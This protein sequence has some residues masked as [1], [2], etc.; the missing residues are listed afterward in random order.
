V[1]RRIPLAFL[2]AAQEMLQA[3]NSAPE[4]RANSDAANRMLEEIYRYYFPRTPRSGQ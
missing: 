2:D 1:A 4:V 3:A